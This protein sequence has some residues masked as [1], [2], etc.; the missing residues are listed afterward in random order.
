MTENRNI[1]MGTNTLKQAEF[2]SK[3]LP[4]PRPA[5]FVTQKEQF[6]LTSLPCN[7]RPFCSSYFELCNLMRVGGKQ[8]IFVYIFEMVP[9]SLS[10]LFSSRDISIKSQGR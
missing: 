1:F 6:L 10:K 2:K 8:H 7:K 5:V 9:I 4:L 3:E